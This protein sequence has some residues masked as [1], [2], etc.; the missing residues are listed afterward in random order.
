MEPNLILMAIPGFIVLIGVEAVYCHRKGLPYYRLHDTI[1]DLSMG[2]A[3]QVMGGVLTLISL[4]IYGWIYEHFRVVTLDSQSPLTWILAILGYD[5]AYYWLHR[6]SHTL[7]LLWGGHAP[8][9]Q[10]E[11]YNLAVAL[12]QGSF[13][14]FL[15]TAFYWP[16]ALL[17]FH[18]LVTLTVG[19]INTIYQFWI[20]TRTVKQLGYLEL[21]LNTP[22]HH[23]V[24]HGK[25]PKYLDKNH[26]GM[27][28]I[29]DKLFGTFVPE[30]EEPVY[31]VIDPLRSWNPVWGHFKFYL[32]LARAAW[33]S[34]QRLWNLLRIWFMPAG[35][36]P[37]HGVPKY[38]PDQESPAFRAKYETH[39]PS[40]MNHY[41]LLHFTVVLLGAVG[42]LVGKNSLQTWENLAIAGILIWGLLNLGGIMERR[43]WA[44][45]AE[46]WR[47]ILVP[48]FF[49]Y[50]SGMGALAG[51]AILGASSLAWIGTS[52]SLFVTRADPAR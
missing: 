29:W 16:L 3:S 7:N 37:P 52:G 46:L 18:P 9:H 47:L 20:H 10:S 41:V 27:F 4:G 28:I 25:N 40:S 30:E 36:V 14:G 19:Q 8:H 12:R 42:Y 49:G 45:K 5:L 23:R 13:Q 34:E 26:A 32:T 39:L 17:G 2:V 1:S 38:A 11:D 21:F 43:A 48:L 22:S 44:W 33:N 50:W 35:W 24:H 31:G 51:L 6:M 15:T